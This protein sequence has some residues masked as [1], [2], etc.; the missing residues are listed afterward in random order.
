[1][2]GR[3]RVRRIT[4]TLQ[5][6]SRTI[7]PDARYRNKSRRPGLYKPTR[8][9]SR[10]VP[11]TP[12]TVAID[13][14]ETGLCLCYG[15]IANVSETGACVW[16][17][18]VLATGSRLVLRVSFAHPPEVHEMLGTVVWERTLPSPASPMAPGLRRFGV[19]WLGASPACVRRLREMTSRALEESL[20]PSGRMRA[21]VQAEL[22]R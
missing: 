13:D 5:K 1:M 2:W 17:N 15:V 12:I 9:R 7:C 3:L 6:I 14:E 11:P 22:E 4:E 10:V 20:T 16:T 19:E 21:L 18:G 8:Q